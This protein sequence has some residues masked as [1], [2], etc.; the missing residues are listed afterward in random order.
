MKD[1]YDFRDQTEGHWIH[2]KHIPFWFNDSEA[3]ILS[4][5]GKEQFGDAKKSSKPW[6][7]KFDHID[8]SKYKI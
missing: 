7:L 3:E 5:D 8:F 6:S 1:R 2:V 4:L